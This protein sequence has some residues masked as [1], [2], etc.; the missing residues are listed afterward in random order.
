M[1]AEKKKA[2]NFFA[3]PK[4]IAVSLI[5]DYAS[6]RSKIQLHELLQDLLKKGEPLDDKTGSTEKLIHVIITLSEG[7]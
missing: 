7:S 2:R 6:V 3:N 1:V 4:A 5:Y